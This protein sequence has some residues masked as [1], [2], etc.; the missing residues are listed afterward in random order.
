LSDWAQVAGGGGFSLAIKTNNTLW[1]WGF[2]SSGQLGDGTTVNKSSPVQIG[3]L[4]DWSQVAAGS[5]HSLAVKTN[6]TLWA[7]GTGTSGQLG[8]GTIVNKSS[9][10][11]IGSLTTWDSLAYQPVSIS[12]IGLST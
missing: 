12:S 11:Q 2:N 1:A 7:W 6:G 10:V 8:D 5:T 9:P 3:A 4:S